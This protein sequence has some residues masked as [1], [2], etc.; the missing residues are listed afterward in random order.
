[1]FFLVSKSL[2]H[3][4]L[5]EHKDRSFDDCYSGVKIFNKL[6]SNIMNVNG[7]ITK[8]KTTLERFLYVNWFY[9]LELYFQQ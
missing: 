1:M 9:T 5:N 3:K 6:P 8:F 7:N 2:N 4:G